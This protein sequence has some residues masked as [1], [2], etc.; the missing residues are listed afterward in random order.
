MENA[1]ETLPK[2]FVSA[3][4]FCDYKTPV[5]EAVDDI[6]RFGAVIVTKQGR[7]FGIVDTRTMARV[8]RS[9]LTKGFPIGKLAI[10][11]PLIDD[12]TSI[13]NAILNFHNTST[14]VL[15]YAEKNKIRGVINREKIL[16]AM[17]SLHTLSKFKVADGMSTPVIGVSK[18]SNLAQAIAAMRN[19]NINRLLVIDSGKV[20]GILTYADIMGILSKPSERMPKFKSESSSMSN[21]SVSSVCAREV[22]SIEHDSSIEDAMREFLR[23][24]ISSLLV[25]RGGR[26]I[27]II[28]VNDV[29]G[30]AVANSTAVENKIIISGLDDYTKEYEEEITNELNRVADKV[31]RFSKLKVDSIAVNVRRKRERNYEMKAR[32][33]LSKRG[34]II[35]YSNGYTI[36]ETLKDLVSKIYRKIKT[37]KEE[38]VTYKKS[39]VGA[40]EEV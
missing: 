2:E 16:S 9:K 12:G 27:G 14:K 19:N 17:L 24:N 39:K 26:P 22:Y 15:P 32:V 1:F 13:D 8:Q 3:A 4:K 37:R 11:A 20:F 40:Y 21:I 5:M 30:V 6:K 31:G 7:Y 10:K 38:I 34:S 36:S 25:T 29:F 18:D 35:V 23:R 33:M 28:T